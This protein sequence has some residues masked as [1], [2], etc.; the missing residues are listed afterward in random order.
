MPVIPIPDDWAGEEWACFIVE[1]P[2]SVQWLAL[3]RGFMTAASRGRFW[4]P[5]TGSIL[6][7]QEVGRQIEERNPVTMCDEMTAAM[8]GIQAAVENLDVS[9]DLQVTIQTNIE[10]KISLVA[11]AVAESLAAQSIL[12][13]AASSSSAAANASAFAWSKAIAE[14]TSSITIINNTDNQFRPIDVAIDLPP[15]PREEAPTGITDVLE[16]P[17]TVEVC[18][19]SYWLVRD[20]KEYLN[21]LEQVAETS[22]E[23]V[24]G[25]SGML[26]DALWVSALRADV[27]AARFLIPAAVF[28]GAAHNLQKLYFEGFNPW[29]ELSEW[30]NSEYRLLVC[31]VALAV[32]DEESTEYIK[33]LMLGSMDGY[34]VP[35]AYQFIPLLVFNYSSLAALYFVSPL[36]DPAPSVPAF[37]PA[38]ICS[39]CGE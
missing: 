13:V 9:Q 37:E 38:G 15:Q 23:T 12:L 8:E 11:T 27:V 19:R 36:T 18:K 14:Q 39:S 21:Y 26:S 33:Q 32:E 24:L 35:S 2:N 1:W 25:L 3:L 10:N 22:S 28:L 29:A 17:A 7:A 30:I 20:L 6:D 5:K 34:G 16:N 31:E 4:D